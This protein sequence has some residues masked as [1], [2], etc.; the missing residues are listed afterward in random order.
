[1]CSFYAKPGW[2]TAWFKQPEEIIEMI[3]NKLDKE[4]NEVHFVGGLWRDANL[5]YY[6]ECFTGIKALDPNIHIKAL[7]PVEY[8]FLA[9]L[10]SISIEEVF[11]KMISWG[12]ESLPGG[13]AEILNDTIRKKVAPGKIT[14]EEYLSIHKL[15]HKKG[16]KSNITM[17]FN[18]IES[19]ADIVDHCITV[20]DVQ[21]ETKGFN[22]FVPLKYHVENNALGKRTS[23]HRI[24]DIP[25][26]YAISRLLLDNVKNIKVLWNYL[27]VENALHILRCGANDLASTAMEERIIRLAGGTSVSMNESD[28]TKVISSIGRKPLKVHSGHT[29]D[30]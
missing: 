14:T 3:K 18:H 16:I 25:L 19:E 2:D 30:D 17:L 8:D 10:D 21:D 29:Y 27:G 11:E 7:T 6:N 9:K 12:L 20:R 15:A 13:G 28:M 24:K 23:R 1:M 26:V 5:A 4:I 22:C